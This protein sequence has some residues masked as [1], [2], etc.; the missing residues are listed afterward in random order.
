M[1][2]LRTLLAAAAALAAFAALVAPPRFAPAVAQDVLRPERAYPYTAEAEGGRLRVRFDILDGYYLYRAKFS[3]ETSTPGVSLGA[4]EF[5]EGEIHSDE[6]FGEQEIYRGAFEISIPYTLTAD[7]DEFVLEM[8]LQ[9]CADIGL[10]YPPQHWSRDVE[11]PGEGLGGALSSL[12]SPEPDALLPV[13]QAFV[14]NARFDGPN[15]LVVGWQIAPGYYLYRDK[16][17]ISAVGDIELGEPE[18]PEGVAHSDENFGDVRVF[19]DYVEATVPFARAG[20]NEIPVEVRAR[21]QGCRENSICYPPTEQTMSLILPA[22]S[23]FAVSDEPPGSSAAPV[24]EQDRLAA[25]ILGGSWLAVGGAFFGFGLLL[26]FTPCVLPMVPI[27]S[28]IIVGQGGQTSAGRGFAL[29]LTYV[30]GMAVTYTVAGAL[31]ALAGEQAQ[32]IFQKPWIISLF[33]GFF[34]LLALSMF[35]VFNLQMPAAVQTRLASLANRQKAGTFVGTGIMGALSALIVTTCVAPPLFAALA[36]I[37]QSGDVARGAGALFALSLGMGAPLLVVGASAGKLLPKAGPWMNTVKA[38]F[39]VMLL[40]LA[41]WMMERVLPGTVV[42]VLWALL[43]F[44]T[45]VFLGAFE[46]LPPEP[47]PIRRLAKGLGVLACL[48]GALML[49]GATL[50]GE[51]PLRPI[52]RGG[53]LARSAAPAAPALE[54]RPVESVAALESALAAAREAGRPVMVDFTA[55]WCVSCKEMEKYTFPDPAVVAALEPFTLLRADVT[56]N[57]ADDK[58][59]LEYFGS[60]GPPTIA[61]FDDSGRPQERY[62]LVGFVPADDFAAH[63]ERVA[64]L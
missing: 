41:L 8:G 28:G 22:T 17:E 27:L 23:E 48:Y 12:F 54:F 37:G 10:C 51:D 53:L 59:L 32:A 14:M 56:A 9:G 19:Y 29:S 62:K 6:F 58:A 33:A 30:L 18:L 39:G 11:L 61:F 31:A 46:P 15:E 43:V 50:G 25:L 52:P 44:L 60:F 24:S 36:V 7:V 1:R 35:G 49:I 13:D 38:A 26:A 57:D 63:V 4:P 47:S 64:A 45:G 16:F 55:D 21:F 40:G 5:P 34:V 20:P 3:F 2:R 42:L